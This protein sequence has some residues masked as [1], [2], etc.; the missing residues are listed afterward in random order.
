MKKLFPDTE[1]HCGPAEGEDGISLLRSGQTHIAVL[2]AHEAYPEDIAARRL[3]FQSEFAL[4][5]GKT[6]PLAQL[7]QLLEET[8]KN[9]SSSPEVTRAQLAGH[10]QLLIKTYEEHLETRQGRAWS[11]P[12]YLSLLAFAVQGFG[13]A[14]LP[15]ALVDKFGDGMLVELPVR[16][17]PRR[18]EIDVVWMRRTPLGVAGQWFIEQLCRL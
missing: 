10:R 15:R 12:D 16:G 18:V 1:L 7:T 2:A 14:E 3:A 4:F 17:Y 11:A 13:W 5:V 8:K 6:H 9:K